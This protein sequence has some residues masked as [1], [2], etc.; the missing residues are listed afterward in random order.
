MIREGIFQRGFGLR[1]E[2][3]PN[4]RADYHSGIIERMREEDSA[5]SSPIGPST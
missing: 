1:R 3:E 4:L 2:V 5:G